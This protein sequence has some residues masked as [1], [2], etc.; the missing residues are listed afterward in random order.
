[1]IVTSKLLPRRLNNP[2]SPQSGRNLVTIKNGLKEIDGLLKE[3]LVFA[4]VR[5][6][7]LKQKE[8]RRRRF[9]REKI[10]ERKDKDSDYDIGNPLQRSTRPKPG[11]GGIIGGLA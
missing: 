4:K 10:I 6:R 3:R 11:T 8:E 9:E 1:M 2:S 5:E 7:L